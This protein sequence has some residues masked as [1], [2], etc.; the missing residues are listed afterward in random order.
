[1]IS[2]NGQTAKSLADDVKVAALLDHA[3]E[4]GWWRRS[5]AD[6]LA[7]FALAE[8]ALEVGSNPGAFFHA[9]IR[10]DLRQY[11]SQAQEDRAAQRLAREPRSA[12]ERGVDGP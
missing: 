3:I 6:R 1:M 7:F 5:Q 2:F 11:V 4:R 10:Q 12:A 8:R 9:A